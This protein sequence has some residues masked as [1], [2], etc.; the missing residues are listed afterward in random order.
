MEQNNAFVDFLN[1]LNK[2]QQNILKQSSNILLQSIGLDYQNDI[3]INAKILVV[4]D[5]EISNEFCKIAKDKFE[6]QNIPYISSI[7]GFLGN[8]K[9]HTKDEILEASQIVFFTKV[10]FFEKNK[11]PV[12]IHFANDFKDVAGLIDSIE[13]FIGDFVFE[14]TILYNEEKCQYHHRDKNDISYCHACSDIC[15]TYAIS[16]D[17]NLRE[18]KFSN[19]DCIFCGK[20]VSVCPSGSMQKANAPLENIT[21]AAKLYKDRIPLI[22]GES[23]LEDSL[24]IIQKIQNTKIIPLVLPNINMLNEVYLLSILQESGS[25]CIIYGKVESCL[26]DCVEFINNL[27]QKIYNKKVI[28]YTID[29]IKNCSKE[30]PRYSY[31]AENSEFSREIF[32]QRVNF[33]VK[34]NDYGILDNTPNVTYGNLKI[35]GDKCTLCMSCVEVC[36]AKALINSK[37]NFSLML[38]PSFCTTCG[39]CIDICPENIIEMEFN[40]IELKNTYFKYGQK[41]SDEPFK[42]IECGKI[43]AS[44][45]AIKKVESIMSPIF[46]NDS[47]KQRS[48]LC[49]ADCKVNIIFNTNTKQ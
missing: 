22:I 32:S 15:P 34:N 46:G 40:G 7:S 19:I 21:N 25:S 17:D 37:D 2:E 30:L 12:G 23:D 14:N 47:I 9:A 4:G 42:C 24:N 35:N 16:K 26:S 13:E 39:I 28:F 41:A 27:Y 33:F 8:F 43:F 45:K 31:M 18:L 38:N 36:N 29:D 20:C 49:C 3:S 44:T 5:N 10:D 48:L 6:I 11:I 1:T